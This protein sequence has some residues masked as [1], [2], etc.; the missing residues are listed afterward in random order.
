MQ[1]FRKHARGIQ[2]YLGHLAVAEDFFG[3][4]YQPKRTGW[5][6]E[7]ASTKEIVGKQNRRVVRWSSPLL[8][9]RGGGANQAVSAPRK[10]RAPCLCLVIGEKAETYADDPNC[11]YA[12]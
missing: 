12:G 5:H 11:A 8:E 3:P 6:R 9:R 10:E 7:N 2:A 4:D 1:L